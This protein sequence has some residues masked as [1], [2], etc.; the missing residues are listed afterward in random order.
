MKNDVS[1]LNSSIQFNKKNF[2]LDP[3]AKNQYF[4][5][6][7]YPESDIT[8]METMMDIPISGTKQ[9]DQGAAV[10][11]I[12]VTVPLRT[13]ATISRTTVPTEVTHYNI[14]TSIDLTMSVEGRDLGH[15]ADEVTEILND[16]GRLNPRKDNTWSTYDPNTSAGAKDRPTLEGS[17]IVFSGEY[18]R[19]NQTF[20]DLG[21]GLILA[22]LLM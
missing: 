11:A 4:V 13:I 6:V 9:P 21:I 15:V 22:I 18:A 10:S 1:A 16:F 19:M 20:H 8:S 7:Q 17:E 3:V 12:N 14:Q 2:W 5:G